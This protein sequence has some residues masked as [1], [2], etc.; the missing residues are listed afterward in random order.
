MSDL[1]LYFTLYVVCRGW[2]AMVLDVRWLWRAY[3][4]V[5]EWRAVA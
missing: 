1:E 2:I 4:V 5:R 3:K